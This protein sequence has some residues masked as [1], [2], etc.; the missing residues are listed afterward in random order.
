[1]FRHSSLGPKNGQDS[2]GG[3]AFWSV[4]LSMFSPIPKKPHWPL[5][6]HAFANAGQLAQ[7]PTAAASSRVGAC[8]ELAQPSTAAGVGLVYTQGQ[9]RVELNAGVPLTARRGDGMAK[10]LQ[11]GIGID[12]L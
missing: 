1:M 3:D 8:K 4:G 2:L 5:M 9:L 10:G 12:F 6:L 7:L 11:L